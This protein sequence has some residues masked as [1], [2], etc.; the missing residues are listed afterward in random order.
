MNITFKISNIVTEG[1]KIIV[2]YQFSN[3]VDYSNRFN[4]DSSISE[5]MTWGQIEA[6]KMEAAIEDAKNR[7]ADLQQELIGE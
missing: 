5:I 7:V 3:G 6:E 1:S 4:T 2:F